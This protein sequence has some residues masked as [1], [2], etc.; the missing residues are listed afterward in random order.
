MAILQEPDPAFAIVTPKFEH[1]RDRRVEGG[2]RVGFAWP[3]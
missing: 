3:A 1:R 2:G